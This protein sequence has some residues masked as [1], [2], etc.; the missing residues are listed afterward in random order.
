[1]YIDIGQYLRSLSWKK[2]D[3]ERMNSTLR[4]VLTQ[5]GAATLQMCCIKIYTIAKR[6]P[7]RSLRNCF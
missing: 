2:Q 1:M 6:P 4:F 3:L 5:G 7:R